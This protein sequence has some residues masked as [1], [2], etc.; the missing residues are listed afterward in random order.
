MGIKLPEGSPNMCVFVRNLLCF[1]FLMPICHSSW[2]CAMDNVVFEP[3]H[4]S[5]GHSAAHER[6]LADDLR[7]MFAMGGPGIGHHPRQG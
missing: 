5:G 4:K 7:R 6:E 2:A 1:C 3:K